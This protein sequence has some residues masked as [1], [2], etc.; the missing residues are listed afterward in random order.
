MGRGSRAAGAA[1]R[2]FAGFS[3]GTLNRRAGLRF[4]QRHGGG[5][6]GC[7]PR[8]LAKAA[9][10]L[11][12]AAVAC[13][14]YG[15]SREGGSSKEAEKGRTASLVL[16]VVGLVFGL[17]PFIL[18]VLAPRCCPARREPRTTSAANGR[19]DELELSPLRHDAVLEQ[20]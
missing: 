15:S 18:F 16:L 7:D 6:P 19:R 17:Q 20:I 13:F 4:S 3:T 2:R 10:L 14:L 12:L 5:E 11:L 1:A 8:T 9:F